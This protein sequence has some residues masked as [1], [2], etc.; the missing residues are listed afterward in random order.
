MVYPMRWL[1]ILSVS[2]LMLFS[3]SFPLLILPSI[4]NKREIATQ[5]H[6][7]TEAEKVFDEAMKQDSEGTAES[8]RQAIAKFKEALSL[9]KKVSNR[10]MEATVHYNLGIVYS[11]FGEN[12]LDL[13]RNKTLKLNGKFLPFNH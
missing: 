9:Y 1:S 6:P 2:S 11:H 12:T 10:R 13:S 3:V 7:D 4:V 5:A 8:R